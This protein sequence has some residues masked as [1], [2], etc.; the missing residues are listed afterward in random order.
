MI[1]ILSYNSID[2]EQQ[3]IEASCSLQ[4]ARRSNDRVQIDKICGH[5]ALLRRMQ[6][7]T[8]TDIIYYEIRNGEDVDLLRQLRVKE[9][10][11]L[12][13]LLT[14]AQISPMLYLK[15]GIAPDHLLLRPFSREDLERVNGELFDVLISPDREDEAAQQLPVNTREGRVLIPV[16]KILYF[17]ANN[18]KISVRVGD[19]EFDFYDSIESMIHRMP[20]HF[21]RAHRAYLVNTRKIRRIRLAEG[22]IE[23]EGGAEIPLSR[24]YKA[25]F[26][27]I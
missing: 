9:S 17:E 18:K 23:M 4:T 7:D 11:A 6:A 3:M 22:V 27:R 15:P 2:A 1:S 24:T 10:A 8:V 13:M 26:K 5:P 16:E 21:R 25:D 19:E 12:L 14:S 20:D